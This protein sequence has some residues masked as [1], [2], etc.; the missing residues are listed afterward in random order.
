MACLN[1]ELGGTLQTRIYSADP[2]AFDLLR[3]S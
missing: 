2:T 3:V 1:S